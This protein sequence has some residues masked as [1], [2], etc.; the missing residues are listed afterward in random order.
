MN[1]LPHKG[2]QLQPQWPPHNRKT[3]FFERADLFWLSMPINKANLKTSNLLQQR[4]MCPEQQPG[5]VL[6]VLHQNAVLSYRI[7]ALYQH[8]KILLSREFCQ[9]INAVYYLGILLY[10]RWLAFW[11]FSVDYN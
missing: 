2:I 9:W 11:L 1:S 3:P 10:G 8:K 4:T 6:L 7:A 5:A